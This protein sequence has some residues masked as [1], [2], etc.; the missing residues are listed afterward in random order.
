MPYARLEWHTEDLRR[1]VKPKVRNLGDQG[2]WEKKKP[3][4]AG[5]MS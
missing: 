1:E 5:L 3:G 2:A 4:Q